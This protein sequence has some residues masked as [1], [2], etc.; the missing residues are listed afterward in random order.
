MRALFALIAAGALVAACSGSGGGDTA[1]PVA[2]GDPVVCTTQ[3]TKAG[4]V[5][6]C[7]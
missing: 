5:E 4:A 7:E 3:F 2:E 6:V 1:E